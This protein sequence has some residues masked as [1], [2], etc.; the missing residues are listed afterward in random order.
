MPKNATPDTPTMSLK[1]DDEVRV[2]DVNGA[3]MGQPKDGWVG[4]VV[5][6]GRKL[7]TVRYGNYDGY[8]QVFRR[9]DGSVNDKYGHQRIETPEQAARRVRNGEIHATLRGHGIN[10]AFGH[11]LT[12]EHLEQMAALVGT[13]TWNG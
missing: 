1:V 11:R 10:L 5:K 2:I 12:D 8:T 7:I 9:E 4:K 3:R 6:V 13:F